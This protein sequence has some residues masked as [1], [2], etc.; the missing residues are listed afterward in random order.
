[1]TRKLTLILST[2]IFMLPLVLAGCGSSGNG[3]ELLLADLS[4]ATSEAWCAKIYECCT[5][6]ELLDFTFTSE[7]ECKT[8]VAATLTQYWVTP[9]QNAITASRGEYDAAKAHKCLKAFQAL[10][11]V[12]TNDP[13]AFFDN[14][15]SPWTA[16]QAVDQDC[17]S[18]FE[19]VEGTYCSQTTSKCVTPAAQNEACTPDQD[20]YCEI[21][22]YCDGAN[23]VTRKAANETCTDDAE[24]ALGT[25]C[26][27]GTCTAVEPKCT[28]R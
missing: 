16:K 5:D 19:C 24:C 23:C 25:G 20:P 11:C 10:G 7:A 28:G 12:G 4:A 14:C 3:E 22:L 1:M 15:T 18:Q 26:I 13:Q 9:M 17:A 21:E 2:A 6:D 27:Q 8:D